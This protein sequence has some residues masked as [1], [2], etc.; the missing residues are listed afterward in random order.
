MTERE[1][2]TREASIVDAVRDAAMC[3]VE[4]AVGLTIEVVQAVRRKIGR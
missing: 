1:S 4:V 2:P 3:G